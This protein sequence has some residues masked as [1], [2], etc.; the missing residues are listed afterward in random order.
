MELSMKALQARITV[1]TLV[2]QEKDAAGATTAAAEQKL[3]K[4]NL[5]PLGSKGPRTSTTD[6]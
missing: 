1:L 4:N 6:C 2:A 5:P 3:L